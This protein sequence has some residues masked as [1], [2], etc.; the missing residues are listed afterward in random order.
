MRYKSFYNII[1]T[2]LKYK[3]NY[4]TIVK[5]CFLTKLFL[6]KFNTNKIIFKT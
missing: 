5:H 4:D 3:N 2:H 1:N 6:N